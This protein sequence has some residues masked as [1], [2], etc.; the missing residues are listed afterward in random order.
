MIQVDSPDVVAL[1]ERD[2]QAIQTLFERYAVLVANQAA[3]AERK[4]LA[5]DICMEIT[6][7]MRLENEMLYPVARGAAPRS[8]AFRSAESDHAAT[9]AQIAQ[10]LGMQPEEP[11]YDARV[12]ALGHSTG[13]HMA[14]EREHLFPAVRVSGVDLA[15]LGTR[16]RE[17]RL[18]L[19][20]VSDALREL[21]MLPAYA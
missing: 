14:Q 12:L 20:T 4:A 9:R 19:Q 15:R 13:R 6:I 18:E 10:L 5:D 2:H 16:V 7:H 8:S 11:G 21:A 1:M 3:P 17:R